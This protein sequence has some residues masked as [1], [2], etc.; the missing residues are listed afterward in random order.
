[1]VYKCRHC[2]DNVDVDDSGLA[3]WYDTSKTSGRRK[4]KRKRKRKR[5]TYL[6]LVSTC[7]IFAGNG[8]KGEGG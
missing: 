4:R 7:N 1:M 6:F 5:A 2:Y 8:G 3:D